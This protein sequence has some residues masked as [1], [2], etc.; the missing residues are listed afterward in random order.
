M[1]AGRPL[2]LR[3]AGAP[4]RDAL[5]PPF[6]HL[7]HDRPARKDELI[8]DVWDR[9]TSG[10][11]PPPFPWGPDGVLQMGEV[12]G[13]NEDGIRTVC[14][15]GYGAITIVDQGAGRALFQVPAATR[16][17]W[18]ERA[19][20]LRA[21]L[22]H[23]LAPTGAMLVHA[24]AVGRDRGAALIV[25]PGG[26]GKSTLATA[27]ALGGM[28]F[29]GEDYVALTIEPEPIAHSVHT[30]AKLS[31][32][33]LELLPELERPEGPDPG[34]D[35]KH[36]ID[37]AAA[38]PQAIRPELPVSAIVAPQV[39]PGR[40]GWRRIAGAEGL[41]A[42]AP[43]TML[44]LPLTRGAGMAMMAS[45]ARGVPSYSLELGDDPRGAVVALEEVLADAA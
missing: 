31:E 24:G 9:E 43:S 8:I 7:L 33:S 39:T 28:G 36:V 22:H 18:Y 25:G 1:V 3:F 2:T 45:L 4:M 30:T 11:E 17:P 16:L 34:P 37:L 12:D 13:F 38:R 26:S 20:P 44:Q 19:A 23:L 27:A 5:A 21:A 41:R 6:G 15:P 42:L 14:D 35:R 10:V 32:R 29:C 40:P